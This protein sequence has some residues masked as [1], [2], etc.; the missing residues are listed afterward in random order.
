MAGNV[1]EWWTPQISL[2]MQ[3]KKKG[4]PHRY[5]W[6]CTRKR[7]RNL[8]E[9]KYIQQKRTLGYFEINVDGLTLQTNI[10]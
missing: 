4:E 5:S 1:E 10:V 2:G 8:N 6:E 3:K 7:R 9:R